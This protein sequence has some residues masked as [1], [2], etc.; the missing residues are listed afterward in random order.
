MPNASD[1]AMAKAAQGAAVALL[2]AV[3]SALAMAFLSHRLHGG[4]YI[5]VVIPAL[6]GAAMGGLVALVRSRFDSFDGR[7]GLAASMLAG[8]VFVLAFQAFI[9]L[10]SVDVPETRELLKLFA[11][12][13]GWWDFIVWTSTDPTGAELSPLGVL[14]RTLPGPIVTVAVIILELLVTITAAVRFERRKVALAATTRQAL[15]TTTRE[16]L[17]LEAPDAVLLAALK[18]L[19]S[20]QME[21]AAAHLAQN[22]GGGSHSVYLTLSS[23]ATA[24]SLLEVIEVGADGAEQV[25]AKRS[26]SSWDGQTLIDELRL[27][28]KS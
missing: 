8:F 5:P 12:G 28:K 14:G 21:Q 15:P 19:D 4:P 18:A 17:A 11:Q 10:R 27:A 22:P 7:V 9:Y 3:F 26:L 1:E 2:V 23:H 6:C 13:D 16:C 20:G 24:D 25:R